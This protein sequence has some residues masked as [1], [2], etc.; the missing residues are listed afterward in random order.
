M[1]LIPSKQSGR[2]HHVALRLDGMF[3][4]SSSLITHCEEPR[5]TS[6]LVH[7]ANRIGWSK[8]HAIRIFCRK[9]S[10]VAGVIMDPPSL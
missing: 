9:S 1:R 3:S 8:S 2:S 10:S 6:S 5:R 4:A 7:C